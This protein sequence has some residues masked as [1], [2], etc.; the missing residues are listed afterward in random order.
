M[1][2][3][4]IFGPPAAGKMTV[5]H[6]LCRLT[7]YK[8]F[9]NHLTVEPVLDIFEFGSPPYNRLVDEFRRRVIEEAAGSGLPG[10]V[11]TIVWGLELESDLALITSYVELVE[12]RGGRVS[13]VELFSRLEE[14][15]A[16][17]T[18]EFRLDRKRSKRDTAFSERNLLDLEERFVMNTGG[19]PTLAEKAWADRE[20]LRI[21]NSDLPADEVARRV[22]AAFALR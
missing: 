12:A 6:E 14:R 8:L 17:N 16:R 22:A 18:T 2:L 11:F 4:V 20:Y 9:H 15:L 13:F 7:G 1:H 21:D 3:V 19:V 5:G 10:L